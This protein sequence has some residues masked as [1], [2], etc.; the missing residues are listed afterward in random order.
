MTV[1]VQS[2]AFL[3]KV[4]EQAGTLLLHDA[5]CYLGLGMQGSCCKATVSP[6]LVG[7][8]EYEPSH[9]GPAYGAGAHH[10][11]FEGN[12]EGTFGQVFTTQNIGC[13]RDG[14]HLGMGR[15]VAKCLGKVVCAGYDA[16]FVYDDGSYGNLSTRAGG[17]GLGKCLLHIVSVALCGRRLFSLHVGQSFR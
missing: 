11:G 5:V 16:P 6:F 9:L 1:K 10:A 3:E 4:G 13:C 8:P 12:V 17:L 15:N 2:A 14:L 7:S